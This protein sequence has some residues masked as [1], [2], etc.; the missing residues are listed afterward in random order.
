M[1]NRN[2]PTPGRDATSMPGDADN[3]A[4]TED[5][6]MDALMAANNPMALFGNSQP[7]A[8]AAEDTDDT[9][10]ADDTGNHASR[11]DADAFLT[12]L[13][14]IY[15]AHR[16]GQDADAYLQQAM[17]DAENAGDD[18]GL[19]TVLN[20]TMG[21]YRSQGRHEKPVDCAAGAGA[22]LAHGTDR[23]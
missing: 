12:G 10:D 2:N 11:F 18:A 5:T 23:Q 19:L 22:R 20:E 8:S 4:C 13:D 3:R 9:G 16:A 6:L 14:A 17:T 15:T 7:A 1:T 21:F